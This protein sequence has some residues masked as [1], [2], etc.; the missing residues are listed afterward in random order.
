MTGRKIEVLPPQIK[1][2]DGRRRKRQAQ[3]ETH[4]SPHD[5][6]LNSHDSRMAQYEQ[7]SL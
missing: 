1:L 3:L 4:F 7:E 6:A 5:A 2:K